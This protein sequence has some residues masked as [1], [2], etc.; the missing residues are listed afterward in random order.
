MKHT[1]VHPHRLAAA[2]LAAA[3]ALAFAAAPARAEEKKLGWADQAEFAFL[4]TAGNTDTQTFGF[5]NKFTYTWAQSLATFSAGG[6]RVRTTRDVASFVD[7]DG[8][9]GTPGVI[10]DGTFEETETTAEAYYASARYDMEISKKL[11]WFA[12]TGWDRNTFSGIDNRYVGFGGVGNIWLDS[13]KEKLRTDYGVTYTYQ[14]EV[15]PDPDPEDD[16]F[17]GVRVS[18]SYMNKFTDRIQFNHDTVIDENGDETKDLRG[19][20]I[21]A[22]A[23]TLTKHLALKVSLQW[24][25]D[26]EPSFVKIDSALDATA[27]ASGV[28]NPGPFSVEADRLDTIFATSLV[29]TF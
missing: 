1:P 16:N 28:A 13:E 14:D 27:L 20:M 29:V 8:D 26:N 10:F 6:I 2:L 23:V 7:A 18:W 4:A 11:F 9:P 25:Y 15:Q 21:N 17:W 24:L 3:A 22:L 19:N 12:G 5:K